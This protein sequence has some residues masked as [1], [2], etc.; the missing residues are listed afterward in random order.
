MTGPEMYSTCR[1]RVFNAC[2]REVEGLSVSS[3][4]DSRTTWPVRPVIPPEPPLASPAE[5]E[6]YEREVADL[7]E[8]YAAI[9]EC[10]RRQRSEFIRRLMLLG[11]R[12]LP[13]EQRRNHS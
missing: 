1:Q 12:A 13:P 9:E 2:R 5:L 10:P 8:L 6:A 3:R 7:R 11:W 4:Q